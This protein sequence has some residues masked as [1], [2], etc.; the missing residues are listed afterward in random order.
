MHVFDAAVEKAYG[1][2]RKLHWMEVF[3]G[4]KAFD[5]FQ[6]WLPGETVQAFEEFLVGIKGAAYHPDWRRNPFAECCL[7]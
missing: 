4:Q 1:G 5:N 7:A 2:K 6:E 3:A